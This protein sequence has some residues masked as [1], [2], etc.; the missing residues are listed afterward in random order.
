MNLLSLGKEAQQ[1]LICFVQKNFTGKS[2]RWVRPHHICFAY[3]KFSQMKSENALWWFDAQSHLLM[4]LSIFCPFSFSLVH[5]IQPEA[6]LFGV[7]SFAKS[8]E[9]PHHLPQT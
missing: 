2:F 3:H 6:L 5:M 8:C 7:K 1:A 4:H 9:N